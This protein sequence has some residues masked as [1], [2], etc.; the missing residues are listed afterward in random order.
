MKNRMQKLLVPLFVLA[1]AFMLC[2]PATAADKSVTVGGK[3]FTEQYLLAQLAGL[4][5]EDEGFDVN[6]KTGVGTNIARQSL[7]NG[8]I[9]LYY[10]N[11]VNA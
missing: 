11:T 5:L 2:S 8:Q 4:L 6:L 9:D 10:E 7:L 1:L 3:N